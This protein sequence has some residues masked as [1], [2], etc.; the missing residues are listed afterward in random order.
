MVRLYKD[1][2]GELIFT[3]HAPPTGTMVSPPT[4]NPPFPSKS[5]DHPTEDKVES[6]ERQVR[7]LQSNLEMYQT[8]VGVTKRPLNNLF[9]SA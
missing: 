4:S 7:A 5:I 2:R 3:H 8:K 1:P 6:L 9:K